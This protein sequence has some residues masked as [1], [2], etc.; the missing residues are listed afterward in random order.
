MP[1]VFSKK[2]WITTKANIGDDQ[3]SAPRKLRYY[4]F[5]DD[6]KP[7]IWTIPFF[8]DYLLLETM[9]QRIMRKGVVLGHVQVSC[10]LLPHP[11]AA[12]EELLHLLVE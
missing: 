2:D 3:S 9:N 4:D 6:N 1:K 10:G 5:N 8:K 11:S 7:Y 12:T